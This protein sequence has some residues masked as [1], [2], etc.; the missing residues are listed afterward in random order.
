MEIN[1]YLGVWVKKASLLKTTIYILY[2]IHISKK[3]DLCSYKSRAEMGNNALMS[4]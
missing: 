1:A 3:Q 2:G 4:L